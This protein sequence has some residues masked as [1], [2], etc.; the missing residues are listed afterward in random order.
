MSFKQNRETLVARWSSGSIQ[1]PRSYHMITL[2]STTVCGTWASPQSDWGWK[3]SLGSIQ[4]NPHSEQH[5]LEQLLRAKVGSW[6]SPRMETPQ[7]L[8]VT[9]S[10]GWLSSQQKKK[11]LYSNGASC[12]SIFVLCFLSCHWAPLIS[13]CL[14]LL[15]FLLPG[16]YPSQSSQPPHVKEVLI[17]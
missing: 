14:C 11:L 6:M 12:I 15:Y 10:R 8:C 3:A 2:V 7:P 17:P 16:I 9:C 4:S 1:Y 13:A 5:Q